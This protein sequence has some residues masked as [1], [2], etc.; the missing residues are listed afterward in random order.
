MLP[1]NK[2]I[3]VLHPYVHTI[4]WAVKMMISL[5]SILNKNNDVTFYTFSY[6]KQK[7]SQENIE[8]PIKV[9]SKSKIFNILLIAFNIR[10]CE[11]VII[12]NSP[13]HFVWVLSKILFLSKAKL[14]WWNHHYPWYYSWNTNTFIFLKRFLEKIAVKKID[15]VLSNSQYLKAVIK[16]I[17]NRNSQILYPVLDKQFE[18]GIVN[19][20]NKS[21]LTLFTYSRWVAWKNISLVFKTYDVLKRQI[22]NLL[23]IVWGLGNELDS[24]ID[25]YKMDKNVIFLWE[26]DK[27]QILENFNKTD[28]FLFPSLVD[29]FWLAVLESLSQ[30][31]PVVCFDKSWPSELVHS[32]INGFC[33][34]SENDFIEKTGLL[35]MDKELRYD[36]SHK[37]LEMARWFTKSSF[38]KQIYSLFI[39]F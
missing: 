14:I 12:W 18:N 35:L 23:L 3:A 8:F 11:Y 1:N 9:L 28:I 30:W 31:I 2:R 34:S 33:V 37:W 32:W 38:E 25:K 36:C 22:T 20:K 4:W 21:Q 5:S 27:S 7:F 39:S 17:Y 6:N 13:M 29:S 26:L 24:Y 19:N 10:K 16:K 15:L